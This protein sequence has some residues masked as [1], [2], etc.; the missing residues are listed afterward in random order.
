MEKE[1]VVGCFKPIFPLAWEYRAFEEVKAFF[2]EFEV[3]AVAKR[4]RTPEEVEACFYGPKK[5]NL[6]IYG[7]FVVND[8]KLQKLDYRF[9]SKKLRDLFGRILFKLI[10]TDPLLER[11]FLHNLI[12]PKDRYTRK[13]LRDNY[14]PPSELLT[15]YDD[16][17]SMDLLRNT[18]LSQKLSI[19]GIPCH[20]FFIGQVLGWLIETYHHYMLIDMVKDAGAKESIEKLRETRVYESN[21]ERVY[22]YSPLFKLT[23]TKENVMFEVFK[24]EDFEGFEIENLARLADDILCNKIKWSHGDVRQ[25]AFFGDDLDV[26]AYKYAFRYGSEEKVIP[27][28][29][30]PKWKNKIEKEIRTHKL[31]NLISKSSEAEGEKEVILSTRQKN[32]HKEDEKQESIIG[33]FEGVLSWN[34][35]SGPA[36]YWLGKNIE[37]RL[38]DAFEEL[39]SEALKKERLERE[40]F[41]YG[42][43][44]DFNSHEKGFEFNERILKEKI[45]SQGGFLDEPIDKDDEE[46]DTLRATIPDETF[47]SP[48]D[49]AFRSELKNAI[50]GLMSNLS[51][52]VDKKIIDG[53]LKGKEQADIAEEL[54]TTPSAINQRIKNLPKKIPKKLVDSLKE[55]LNE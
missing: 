8:V 21:G 44:F 20:L 49:E 37:W 16:F 39:S 5:Q 31:T 48:E 1:K 36:T 13:W 52:P 19:N 47:P 55:F 53:L 29:L 4:A 28:Q 22:N 18:E 24:K 9:K 41:D 35:R 12:A 42:P 17:L 23:L 14:I 26:S 40:K 54:K 11:L 2:E 7:V 6:D 27:L 46:G 32:S 51:D 43:F 15:S 33:F 50:S 25:N 30:L 10:F 3:Y 34:E 38:R 45:E